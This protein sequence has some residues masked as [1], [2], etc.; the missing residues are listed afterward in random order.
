MSRLAE[1]G[2]IIEMK[3]EDYRLRIAARRQKA[4]AEKPL[5]AVN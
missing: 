2:V 1:M 3:A 5:P 4:D